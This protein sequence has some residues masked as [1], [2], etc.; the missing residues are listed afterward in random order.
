MLRLTCL[1]LAL[2]ACGDNKTLPPDSSRPRTDSGSGS[3]GGPLTLD[4][5]SYCNAINTR[6]TGTNQ[7]YANVQNCMDSC[8]DFTAGTLGDSSGNTLGCRLY[9]TELS[10]DAPDQHC[11]HAGPSG[12]MTCG[13]TCEGFCA[14]APVECPTE[15]TVN[16]CASRCANIT[17]T[18][19]YSTASTGNTIE[20]R[21]YHLT[22]AATDPTNHCP[23]TVAMNNPVC[24]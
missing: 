17:S 2:T 9:H 11:V 7:Q 3:N 1:L 8:A 24:Q 18:P 4:C 22:M 15:W 6:C 19:P 23:H 16:Q 10:A 20:C 21:L 14:I 12:G 13:T 5:T